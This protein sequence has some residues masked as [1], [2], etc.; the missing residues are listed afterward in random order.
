MASW[1][2]SMRTFSCIFCMGFVHKLHT[3]LLFA[4]F[5]P[6]FFHSGML[7][8]LNILTNWPIVARVLSFWAI[9]N[10]V[11]I[12]KSMQFKRWREHGIVPWFADWRF[13]TQARINLHRIAWGL[14]FECMLSTFLY[15]I[16][17]HISVYAVSWTT[18]LATYHSCMIKLMSD[19]R[20]YQK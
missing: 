20:F 15:I 17:A 10:H 5:C 8:E 13:P 16:L 11:W 7:F 12:Q 4:L 1:E 6:P 2:P 3:T 18:T 9:A 14:G 19:R